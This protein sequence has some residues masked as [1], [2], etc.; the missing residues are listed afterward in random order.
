MS[1]QPNNSNDWTG[2]I[3]IVVLFCIPYTWPI[4][5]FLLIRKLTGTGKKKRPP[6]HPYDIQREWEAQQ[7][8]Q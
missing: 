5:L 6:R 4:A 2:W 7:R 1:T 8:Q 3:P